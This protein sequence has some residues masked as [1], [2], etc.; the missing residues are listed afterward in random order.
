[1]EDIA[2]NPAGRLY[3]M[4]AVATPGEPRLASEMRGAS[5]SPS[6][7]CAY[8]ASVNAAANV[9]PSMWR[10]RSTA[11]SAAWMLEADAPG[12]ILA[13]SFIPSRRRIPTAPPGARARTLRGRIQAV[14]YRDAN[15]REPVDI[16]LE[17]LL[18][19]RPLAAAKIDDAIEEHLNGR[20]PDTPPPEFPIT[21]Q[22]DGEL[23]EL[24]VRFARTR[25]RLLY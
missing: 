10:K 1:M 23:R 12:R 3:L 2:S 20:Q 22:I 24:R 25:Y 4:T 14:F 21:S 6:G 18:K 5:R 8:V 7:G 9:R 17:E 13:S 11:Y 16:F 19:A 15:G